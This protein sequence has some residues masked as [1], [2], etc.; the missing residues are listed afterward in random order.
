MSKKT[1]YRILQEATLRS[2]ASES[3]G[4]CLRPLDI[5]D[6]EYLT[7]TDDVPGGSEYN[8]VPNN[9]TDQ[10]GNGRYFK[11]ASPALK[12]F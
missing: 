10:D 7:S 5:F 6:D 4:V 8:V 1:A 12:P 11:N 9:T 2:I 3:K